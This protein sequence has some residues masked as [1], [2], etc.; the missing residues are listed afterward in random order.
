M[1][2]EPLPLAPLMESIEQLL[3]AIDSQPLNALQTAA[4]DLRGQFLAYD[5]VCRRAHIVPDPP[6]E[7]KKTGL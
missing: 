1:P 4:E 3:T 6:E 5:P 2:D 7:A